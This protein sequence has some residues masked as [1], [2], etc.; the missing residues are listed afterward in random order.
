MNKRL[1]DLIARKCREATVSIFQQL[2]DIQKEVNKNPANI[3]ELTDL[4]EYIANDLPNL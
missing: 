4:N 2:A 3:E 1:I